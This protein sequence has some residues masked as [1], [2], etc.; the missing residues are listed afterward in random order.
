MVSEV[1]IYLTDDRS[2]ILNSFNKAT[3]SHEILMFVC[4]QKDAETANSLNNEDH[5][6]FKITALFDIFSET[7]KHR[8]LMRLK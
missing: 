3:K 8:N 6:T 1:Y 7:N 4:L 5:Q 2:A